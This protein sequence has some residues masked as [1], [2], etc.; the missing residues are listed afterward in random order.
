MQNSICKTQ[1]MKTHIILQHEMGRKCFKT[2]VN[3]PVQAIG[4]LVSYTS[5]SY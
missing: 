3:K 4:L 5:V 2:G 1:H